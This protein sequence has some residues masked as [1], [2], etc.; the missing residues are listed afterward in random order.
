MLKSPVL[1]ALA[2]LDHQVFNTCSL[3]RR[4]ACGFESF[5]VYASSLLKLF[6]RMYISMVS[7]MKQHMLATVIL[8]VTFKVLCM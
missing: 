2:V 3:C 8:G 5:R 1:W 7:L 6:G 4:L